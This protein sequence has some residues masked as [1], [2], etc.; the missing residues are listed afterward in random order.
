MP[1]LARMLA[2]PLVIDVRP[3]AIAGLADLLSDRKIA[4]EGR[5]AVA[6]GPGQGDAI[7][8]QLPPGS[9][10]VIRII[11]GGYDSAVAL[12]R[13]LRAGSYE[14]VAG[15]GG[16][17]TIDVTKLAAHVAGIPMV[18]VATSLAH[19]GIASPVS[20]L[21]HES[22]SGSYGVVPPVAVVVDLDRVRQAPGA[23]STAGIGDAVSNLSAV[24]DWE[25]SAAD[26]GERVDGLAV[27]MARSAAHAVLHEPGPTTSDEFL[28]VLAEALIL[29]GMA[30]A[31]AG[32]SRRPAAA[33]MRS[34]TRSTSCTRARPAMASWPASARC[35]APTCA[36]APG[37]SRRYRPACS[38]TACRGFPRKS[39][40]PASSSPLRSATPRRPGRGGTPYSSAWPCPR[41]RRPRQWR[42]MSAPSLAELRE[43]GQPQ[44]V[45]DRLNDEHWL[46]RLYGRKLSPYAT[47]VFARLGWSPNAVTASFI[48][49]GIAAGVVIA[50]GGLATAVIGALLIQLYLIFDC[51]DGELA[52]WSN[53]KSASGVFL[54]GV[55]HYLGES[56]VLVGLGFRAQGHFTVAGGYITA[57]VAA[58][59]LAMLVRAETDNVV[60]ARAKAGLPA[61]HDD[62]ALAPASAGLARAR[63]LASVLKIHRITHAVE[64]SLLILVTAIIDAVRGELT[65]TRVLVVAC[66]VVAALMVVAHLV[67]IMASRRL[68]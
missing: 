10:D 45:L 18:A 29:S 4:T 22:G 48:V 50:F 39:A 34:C 41:P 38:G 47:W 23:L 2:A 40:S 27:A 43:K 59:L 52:R 31:V 54:D 61:G 57:G 44:A 58:A 21:A 60:V 7:A 65:A 26:T 15:I 28:T 55:G 19:D 53:R 32:S 14:A 9:V 17:K 25:L 6:V 11:D 35:S 49:C 46:G 5:V 24:A 63:K 33:T 66:L 1:L 67:A 37:S 20:T 68:R 12:G 36:A 13:E 8:A 30:M 3:G 51:S 42:S 64:L 56:A 16:G 62:E